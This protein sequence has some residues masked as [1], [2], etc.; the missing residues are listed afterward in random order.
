MAQGLELGALVI[1]I[2]IVVLVPVVLDPSMIFT[3]TFYAYSTFKFK[4]LIGF[5]AMLL[6]AVLGSV[7]LRRRLT[8]V[9][10]LIPALAFLGV[11][12]L[13]T[14]FSDDI[15]HSLFGDRYDGLL[16]LAAG[17]LLFYAVARYLNSPFQVRIFLAA[18]V[19]A[20]VLISIYGIFQRYG[21]DTISGWSNPW[22][23]D[24][25]RPFSTVGNP[26]MLAAYLTLMMGAAAALSFKTGSS[27][28]HRVPWLLALA[29]IGACWIYTD[30]RGPMLSVMVALP[31]ALWFARHRMGTVRPLMLPIASLIGVMAAALAASA[32]FGIAVSPLL[33]AV[34]VAYLALVG[35]TLWLSPRWKRAVRFAL[36]SLVILGV[37]G[38]AAFA[39]AVM[40]GNLSFDLSSQ[41]RLYIWR[42]TISMILDRPLLGFGPD[43]FGQPFTP[44][45]MSE[46]L[47]SVSST[48][49]GNIIGV[50]KVH[51]ELL[52][53]TVTTGL[54]GLAAYVWIF[55]SYFR[56]VYRRGGW[57]LIALSGG[58]LAYIIQ[59]QTAFPQVDTS[60]AFWGLLGASVA[61]MRIQD[62]ENGEPETPET[63]SVKAALNTEKPNT[64][65]YERAV[66]VAVVGLLLALA[67]PTFLNQR[68]KIV[69]SERHR[70]AGS[71]FNTI[72]TYKQVEEER[73]TYPDA[74][75]YTQATPIKDP[76]GNTV[77][78]PPQNVTVTTSTAPSG[79]L[80][81]EAESV[82]LAGTFRSSF[83]SATGAYTRS[84]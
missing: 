8:G 63:G 2:A 9:P 80:T 70:V 12:A 44:A 60:V 57:P 14:L 53:V 66:V 56:N 39:A 6:V 34:L 11:S 10:V 77:Y 41:I 37:V 45:Y 58:V 21:F 25:G 5:S 23:S 74:G 81:V 47:K 36:F 13:S 82:S 27:W 73:G 59:L 83:D 75:I 22:Y 35:I 20:A 54:L 78:T 71:V 65:T 52:Q 30:K 51:N 1:V 3:E 76:D 16:S 84:P 49:Q 64:R 19:T 33:M 48:P 43:N 79:D 26:I 67:V 72:S 40:S 31:A 38:V 68:E 62:R 61:V 46:D 42:D 32:T 50:D 69:E 7:V 55:V 29:V 15:T 4:V 18:G 17:V 28:R 24:F